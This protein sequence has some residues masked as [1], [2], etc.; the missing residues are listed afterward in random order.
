MKSK[1]SIKVENLD[2]D[3]QV[4]DKLESFLFQSI[5]DDR[6]YNELVGHAFEIVLDE[7][8]P[9]LTMDSSDEEFDDFAQ[10]V[11]EYENRAGF[12]PTEE[13]WERMK[14]EWWED[15]EDV[16]ELEGRYEF[17]RKI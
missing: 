16:P 1:R 2:L 13:E 11:G 4:I 14:R 9:G 17:Q 12:P 10:L 3:R 8:N 6:D 5:E 7:K 15:D